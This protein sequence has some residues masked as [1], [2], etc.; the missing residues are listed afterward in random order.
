MPTAAGS[1]IALADFIR[2]RLPLLPVPGIGEIHLHKAVPTSG[3]SRFLAQQPDARNQ[4]APYWAHHWGGGLALAR[5]V[6]DHSTLV[7]GRR[8]LDLGAGSGLV[9]IAA[10]QAGAAAVT[11]AETD[12]NAIVAMRLNLAANRA[13]ANILH[14][15][16]L[17]D[18]P[19]PVD[20]VLVGDLFYE[21][22][23][24]MRVI[25][26]LDRCLDAGIDVLIGDPYRTSLPLQRLMHV[27][28]HRI[29]ET[30]NACKAAGVFR[31]RPRLFC[32]DR[33]TTGYW[34]STQ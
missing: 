16:I 27:A 17:D 33:V 10:C 29:A 28:D 18:R 25:S 9:A 32:Q 1:D 2:A 20:V 26:Y 6:L 22:A 12:R 8:I 31:I 34:P 4:E 14:A 5:H 13:Q 30:A 11:A 21:A 23:L 19:L 15:D 3:L 24:A 7:S